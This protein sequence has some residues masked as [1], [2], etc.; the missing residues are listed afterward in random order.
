MSKVWECKVWC[1]AIWGV[2]CRA[3]GNCDCEFVMDAFCASK[4]DEIEGW[5]EREKNEDA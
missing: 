5:K 4:G 1:R 3:R 2:Q